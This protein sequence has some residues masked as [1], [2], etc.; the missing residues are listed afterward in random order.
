MDGR[1]WVD[2]TDWVVNIAQRRIGLIF[3]LFVGWLGLRMAAMGAVSSPQH[4]RSAWLMGSVQTPVNRIITLA[5]SA[6]ELVY[7]AGAG[8]KLVGV[9]A[10]SDLPPAAK[11][12]PRVGDAFH[13][14]LERIVAMQPDLIVAWASATSQAERHRIQ[15]LGIPV[16][17]LRPRHLRDIGREIDAIGRLAGTIRRAQQAAFHYLSGLHALRRRFGHRRPRMRVFYEITQDPIYTVGGPQLISQVIRLCGGRNIFSGLHTLAPVVSQAAVL[18][19]RPQVIITAGQT[20][21][22]RVRLR[23]WEKWPWLPAVRTHMLFTVP[24]NWLGRPAPTIL[25]GARE[26]C[27]D[28]VEA[29]HAMDTGH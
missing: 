5:P 15:S 21:R 25:D 8:S 1:T 18:A 17:V 19:R 14:D 7:A 10:Y 9:S 11:K 3:I 6:T 16:L 4:N 27:D 23:Y 28:L 12:L 22:A 24:A 2:Y 13:I 29:R 20:A 26:V